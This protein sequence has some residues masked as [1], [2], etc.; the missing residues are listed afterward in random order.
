[1]LLIGSLSNELDHLCINLLHRKE[2]LSFEEV[3]S[4]LLDYEIW[5]KYKREHQNESIEAFTVRG[6]SQNKKWETRGSVTSKSRLGKYECAFCHEKGHWKKDCP[7]LKKKD[8]GNSMSNA[9]VIEYGGDSSDFEFFLVCHPTIVGFDEWILDSSCTYHM[10]P[11]K[12]W[13]FKFEEVDGGVVYMGSGDVSYITGMSSIQLRNYDGSIRVL[14]DVWYVPKLKKNFISLGA[15]E[16]KGLVVIIQDGVLI[17]ILDTLLVMK[18]TRRNNLYYYNS[19]IEIGV[20]ATVPG[21]SE[22]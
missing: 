6:H 2:N 11:H 12:E 10:C 22:D 14:I 21:S 5:K 1:M 19:S 18:G 9:C 4:A 8:K 7:K 20:M 3:C 16:S 13:F 17:V 15:L